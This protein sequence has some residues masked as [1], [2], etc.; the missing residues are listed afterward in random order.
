[1]NMETK[2]VDQV[3]DSNRHDDWLISRY[4]PQRAAVEGI[5]MGVRYKHHVDVRQMM[6]FE[7]RL[8]QPF[9]HLQPLR[10]DRIDQHIHLVRLN[11]KRGVADPGD[12]DLARRNRRKLRRDVFARSLDEQRG[13]ED[14]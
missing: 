6:N 14:L 2:I 10:P 12:A 1:N 9:N 7:S 8:L 11:Q 5:K 3:A 4:L 13:D